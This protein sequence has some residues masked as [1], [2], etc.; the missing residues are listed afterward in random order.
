MF[1]GISDIGWR[2]KYVGWKDPRILRTAS[3]NLD[4][5]NLL[6]KL[7]G[8]NQ[9]NLAWYTRAHHKIYDLLSLG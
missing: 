8:K 1:D 2:D 3:R 7:Q 5:G 6:Y 9:Q 4:Y